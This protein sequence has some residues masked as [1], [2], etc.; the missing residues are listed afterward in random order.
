MM[1]ASSRTGRSALNFMPMLSQ[2]VP[3]LEQLLLAA[4]NVS[5]MHNKSAMEPHGGH[6]NSPEFHTARP[7]TNAV[8]ESP[9]RF[10]RCTH[11]GI[12]A[13][14]EKAPPRSMVEMDSA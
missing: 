7:T 9:T 6:P 12:A 14:C 2:H 10:L 8:R 11:I 1:S 5:S 3:V 4:A 13:K